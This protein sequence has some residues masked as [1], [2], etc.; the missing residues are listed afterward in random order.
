[1][2]EV[3]R[4]LLAIALAGDPAVAAKIALEIQPDDLT[5][6]QGA[7]LLEQVA[8]RIGKGHKLHDLLPYADEKQA[9]YLQDLHRRYVTSGTA[10]RLLG[11]VKQAAQLRKAAVVLA[12]GLERV[13]R[14]DEGAVQAV[15][16]QLS[17]VIAPSMV[18]RVHGAKD[19][20][21]AAKQRIEDMQSGKLDKYLQL[22][23]PAMS[24]ALTIQPGQLILV[25]ARTGVGKTSLAL[26]WTWH[27]A[28][29]RKVPVL[30]L[31]SE[32][33]SEEIGLRLA[34]IGMGVSHL[35]LRVD[36]D[37]ADLA[38]VDKMMTD[39]AD[40]P[41]MTSE[42]IGELTSLEVVALTRHNHAQGKVKVLV[43]DYIQ[44]LGDSRNHQERQEWQVLMDITRTL[45]SLATDL[46]IVVIALAQLNGV[47]D[48]QASKGMANECDLVLALER[49]AEDSDPDSKGPPKEAP[50][51][52]HLMWTQKA[53]H[54]ASDMK[55]RLRMEPATLRFWEAPTDA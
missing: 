44:R 38:M 7:W 10:D 28:F 18:R 27:L 55:F 30:Y 13:K 50:H 43:V 12:K 6:I 39:Y 34:A 36:P 1:M 4:N 14:G 33:S 35:R 22:G 15:M 9:A 25:G 2:S 40:A 42:A 26:T 49:C 37:A 11:E 41:A 20:L 21:S 48:L 19:I 5:E 17:G 52:T 46:G 45:K 24:R 23:L 16:A 47:G 3:E 54:V 32:M 53:R 51:Q 31:N 29:E 8:G